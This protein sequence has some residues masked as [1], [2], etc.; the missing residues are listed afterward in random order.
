M[1]FFE[2]NKNGCSSIGLFFG[3][4]SKLTKACLL[5]TRRG[6][7]GTDFNYSFRP[8]KISLPEVLHFYWR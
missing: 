4:F 6:G 5:Q 1:E 2:S 8:C 3:Y 7:G